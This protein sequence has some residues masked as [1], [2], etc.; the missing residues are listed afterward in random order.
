MT[1]VKVYLDGS[2]IR[3]F[4]VDDLSDFKLFKERVRQLFPS[5]LDKDFT[6]SWRDQEGDF[7]AMS[8]NQELAQA[9]LN[10]DGNLLKIYVTIVSSRLPEEPAAS[11]DSTSNKVHAGVLCDVC[12]TEIQGVRY[13]CLQCED[14][15]LCDACHAKRTHEDHDM[16]KLVNPG[17]RPPWAF[18]GWK[19]LWRH[20][21]RAGMGGGRGHHGGHHRWRGAPPTGGC[22]AFGA[23]QSSSPPQGPQQQQT[24]TPNNPAG[25]GGD[26]N[27]GVRVEYQHLLNNIGSTIANLLDPLGINVA[28]HVESATRG[29]ATPE[30]SQQDSSTEPMDTSHGVGASEAPKTAPLAKVVEAHRPTEVPTEA[31]GAV[32]KVTTVAPVP[33][34]EVPM[35]T[36]GA[37]RTTTDG[38]RTTAEAVRTTPDAPRIAAEGAR[39]TEAPMSTSSPRQSGGPFCPFGVPAE[40]LQESVMEPEGTH[41]WTLLNA[42]RDSFIAEQPSS[43]AVPM[44]QDNA[45]PVDSALS[46]M[47]S[48]GFTNEGGWLKQ[49]L[50]VKQGDIGAVLESLHPSPK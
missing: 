11:G 37:V 19:R 26:P 21:G 32:P 10:V 33:N 47:L 27:Y 36:A 44:Q 28:Y 12:D 43:P 35:T 16:L 20:C 2:E 29:T 42:I 13:K 24:G 17:A 25:S 50:E 18:P 3:R 40:P 38:P 8:S 48:M 1:T 5:L 45:S 46:K 9:V 41:G 31:T 4:V 14:Y 22:P 6:L 15:D 39:V 23:T 7:I 49:L 30:R 34:I